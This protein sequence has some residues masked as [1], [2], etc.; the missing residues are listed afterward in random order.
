[1]PKIVD[2]EARR[3]E[4]I[5]MSARA[6][7]KGGLAGLTFRNVARAGGWST[8]IVSHYFADKH[9]LL[10][11]TYEARA[12]RVRQAIHHAHEGGATLLDAAIDAALPLDEER[13][14]DWRVFLAYVGD[15]F[16]DRRLATLHRRRTTSFHATLVRALEAEVEAGRMPRSL[17]TGAEARRLQCVLLGIAMQ[18]VF[19]PSAWTAGEQRALV[20]AHL[21]NMLT[22]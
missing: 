6:I 9:D 22:E 4:L 14:T 19:E 11:A 15:A 18:A 13:Q 8:G 2:T 7:A 16:G 20:E 12:D 5:R 3:D 10:R 17:D 21:R 1:M